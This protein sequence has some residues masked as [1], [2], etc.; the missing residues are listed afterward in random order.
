MGVYIGSDK[1]RVVRLGDTFVRILIPDRILGV[2]LKDSNNYILKDCNNLYI[3]AIKE[4]E[5]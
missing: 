3:T 4:E 1:K 2:V 5:L